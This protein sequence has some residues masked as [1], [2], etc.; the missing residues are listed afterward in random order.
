M[1]LLCFVVVGNII[2]SNCTYFFHL[3]V[4]QRQYLVRKLCI[5]DK[6][7]FV[8]GKLQYQLCMFTHSLL[9]PNLKTGIS[10]LFPYFLHDS[11]TVIT[12]YSRGN[13]PNSS[14]FERITYLFA[15]LHYIQRSFH[16]NST[17]IQDLCFQNQ[18]RILSYIG[19]YDRSNNRKCQPSTTFCSNLKTVSSFQCIL[20]ILFLTIILILGCYSL[21][22]RPQGNSWDDITLF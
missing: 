12:L 19:I 15:S 18:F 8:D 3:I 2:Q 11:M 13:V 9:G 14:Y 7:V 4:T 17:N 5:L 20:V 22:M 16:L 21:P 6:Y 1:Y 10:R